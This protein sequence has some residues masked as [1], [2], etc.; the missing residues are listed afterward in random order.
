MVFVIKHPSQYLGPV[1]DA[2]NDD[3]KYGLQRLRLC[4]LPAVRCEYS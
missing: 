3:L 1:R 2:G 4:V